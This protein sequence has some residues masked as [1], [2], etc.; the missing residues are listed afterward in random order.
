[1]RACVP[2]IPTDLGCTGRQAGSSRFNN[3][4]VT[5]LCTQ[6]VAHIPAAHAR[7]CNVLLYREP[8]QAHTVLHHT[9]PPCTDPPPLHAGDL[10]LSAEGGHSGLPLGHIVA[11]KADHALHAAFVR[12]LLDSTG[13]DDYVD[14]EEVLGESCDVAGSFGLG[15][16]LGFRV[17]QTAMWTS[18]RCWVSH[19]W[20]ARASSFKQICVTS[21]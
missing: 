4:H 13:D 14:V 17:E 8:P 12:K 18:R 20:M 3:A 16:G 9:M 10:S 2:C 11:Y 5:Y 15:F 21:R 6:D 1:M 19:T 7:A